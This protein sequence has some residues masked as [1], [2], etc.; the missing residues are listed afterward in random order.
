MMSGKGKAL[1]QVVVIWGCGDSSHTSQCTVWVQVRG[2]AQVSVKSELGSHGPDM[3]RPLTGRRA[4]WL[5]GKR[6]IRWSVHNREWS[7]WRGLERKQRHGE[8]ETGWW[9]KQRAPW[10]DRGPEH[11]TLLSE[12]QKEKFCYT[13]V[14]RNGRIQVTQDVLFLE[15]AIISSEK[16]LDLH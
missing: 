10:H 7:E 9:G 4:L 11:A 6:R 2:S 16:G 3:G 8:G 14:G 12:P 1:K 15:I 5:R 13:N